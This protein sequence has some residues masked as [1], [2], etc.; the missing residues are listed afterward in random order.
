MAEKKE[1]V[2]YF[3]LRKEIEAGK[4]QP[5]YLL[6]G[7]EPYYIDQLSD[8]I[9]E[10]ALR[11]DERDFNLSI[12]YGS[13]ANVREVI[14]TCKQY[15][16]F[17]QYKVVVLREAQNVNK[18]AGGHNKDLELFKLYAENPLR[19]TILVVCNKDGAIKAKPFV[20]TLKKE[21]TGVVFSSAKVRDGRDLQGVISNYATS[22]GCNI[23]FKSVTMLADC[24]GNDLSRMFS[25]LDK[26]KLLV[27]EGNAITPELI[28]RNIGISKD[29]NNFEFE[30]AIITRNAAKVYRIIDYYQ[31]NPKNNPVP[32][33]VAMLFSFFSGVLL[34]RASKDQSQAALMAAAGT[35]SAWRLGKFKEAARNY[36]TQACVNIIGYLRECDVRC[37]GMGSRQDSYDL[38]K[39]LAYKI[40]HS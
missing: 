31:K 7:D 6:Q 13:D 12:Y 24:I 28:E 29:Y 19:S 38:L 34:V 36:S 39:E 35:K 20:D 17:S 2:S 16:A 37:K 40:L 25:E 1:T 15:P 23:D 21:K 18:Q 14:S 32:M 8:L 3:S 33:V 4:F 5:I 22:I 11:E 27:K 9:V 26:L 10:K 30:D